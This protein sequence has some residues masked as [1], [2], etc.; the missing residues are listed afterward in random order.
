MPSR[1]KSVALAIGIVILLTPSGPWTGTVRAQP[2][3]RII[4]DG[5]VSPWGENIL[6]RDGHYY[7][8][9]RIFF[10]QQD[11]SVSWNGSTGRITAE[12]PGLHRLELVPGEAVVTLDG[13]SFRIDPPP[14]LIDGT[15]YITADGNSIPGLLGY[16]V[17]TNRYRN[18]LYLSAPI[19][20]IIRNALQSGGYR[21]EGV[22]G[23]AADTADN[24]KLFVGGD[25]VY[26][27]AWQNGGMNG[28]GRVYQN[29][30][31]VYEGG[32]ADNLPNGP[33]IRY[34]VGNERYEGLFKQGRPNGRGKLFA[35]DRLFYEG[36]WKDGRMSGNG[37]LYDASAKV[38]F[39]GAF[40]AGLR[41]GFGVLYDDSGSKV[42]EGNWILDQRYGFGK[43][44]DKDGKVRFAGNW[45][46]DKESGKGEIRRFGKVKLYQLDGV[47]PVSEEEVEVAYVSQVE[48][49]DGILFKQSGLEMVYRGDFNDAGELNG[50]G[51]A[52]YITGSVAASVGVLNRWQPFYKGEFKNGQ[53]SGAGVFYNNSGVAVYDGQVGGGKQTGTGISYTSTGQL[54]FYGTWRD[55]KQNG[56][57]WV[58][59][60]DTAD[61]AVAN[62]S[63]TITEADFVDGVQVYSGHAYRVYSNVKNGAGAGKGSQYWIYDA[64]KKE[65]LIIASQAGSK[66]RLVYEGEL[67]DGLRHGQGVET[68][69]NGG[70]YTGTFS[71][72]KWDGIG[73]LET[74]ENDKAVKYNGDFVNG[75]KTGKG[76]LYVN[77][78]LV[79]EGQFLNDS[80]SGYGVSY[81]DNGLKEYE[82]DF[83][84]DKF[85]GMGTLY[86]YVGGVVYKGEFRDG[87]PLPEYN[88]LHP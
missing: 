38:L 75:R 73:V 52:G 36:D 2:D 6:V 71:H 19:W 88:K 54:Q 33:G 61:T 35:G 34:D 28:A 55:G 17:E 40:E 69:P 51:E 41:H 5:T 3:V 49:K 20:E 60:Y 21:L 13:Q 76:K 12:K 50:T 37:K 24:A 46:E 1:A 65:S 66:G 79:Y 22:N 11:Y 67:L 27:G 72:N 58:Y 39:E 43:T 9:M 8:P 47:T 78:T 42:Y 81:Y 83:I 59:S 7:L 30:Q 44:F 64:D 77:Q 80:R 82:G 14:T 26:E 18:T 86:D 16:R 15:L 32:L 62:T 31:V 74:T 23:G 10:E 29:G 84:G 57:G 68:L 4:V 53:I 56:R 25:L 70:K 87:L 63:F 85:Q 45:V 48:Y